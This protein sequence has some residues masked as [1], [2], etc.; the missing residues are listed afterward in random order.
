MEWLSF[1]LLRGIDQVR[2][3][4]WSDGWALA[5]E[6]DPLGRGGEWSLVLGVWLCMP[7]SGMTLA[8]TVGWHPQSY[9]YVSW[10]GFYS[11]WLLAEGEAFERNPGLIILWK[12]EHK[13]HLILLLL[14]S[15][16]QGALRL[17]C[18]T[19]GAPWLSN[20]PETDTWQSMPQ[21]ISKVT[22]Q[23]LPWGWCV[24]RLHTSDNPGNKSLYMLGLHLYLSTQIPCTA[25][26]RRNKNPWVWLPRLIGEQGV[27]S[28]DICRH[29][30]A[31]INTWFRV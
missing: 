5:Q 7:C 4:R 3:H 25:G 31:K 30:F 9:P 26:A 2:R 1:C 18:L 19:W 22:S 11:V 17:N 8:R 23:D 21:N 16:K 24:Q 29:A 28:S 15:V 14:K 13:V 6:S 12:F 27:R 10:K 20:D